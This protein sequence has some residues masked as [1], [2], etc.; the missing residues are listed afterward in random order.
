VPHRLQKLAPDGF[1]Q[2]HWVQKTPSLD[3][4]SPDSA[5]LDLAPLDLAPLDSADA[6]SS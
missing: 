5:P 4:A 2:P 6:G 3:A 1:C